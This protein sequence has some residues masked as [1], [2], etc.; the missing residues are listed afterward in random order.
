MGPLVRDGTEINTV[1]EFLGAAA[2][3]VPNRPNQTN[4]K[5]LSEYVWGLNLDRRIVDRLHL[6]NAR[7]C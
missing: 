5:D 2:G 3:I 7:V 1:R 6:V 4:P